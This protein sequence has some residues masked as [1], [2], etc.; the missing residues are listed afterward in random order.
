MQLTQSQLNLPTH[1]LLALRCELSAGNNISAN[2][3]PSRHKAL[4]SAPIT[5]NL[6][7]A[8]N[9]IDSPYYELETHTLEGDNVHIDLTD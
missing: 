9:A 8:I 2:A 6:A 1:I 4:N 5:I 7:N 3:T